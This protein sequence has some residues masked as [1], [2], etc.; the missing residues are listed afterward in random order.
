MPPVGLTVEQHIEPIEENGFLLADFS[1]D[2]VTLRYFRFN[3]KVQK[4]EDVDNLQ[5][6]HET[7][8]KRPA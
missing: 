7:T 6:F 4:P 8:L 2:M 3:A 5:P 1:P